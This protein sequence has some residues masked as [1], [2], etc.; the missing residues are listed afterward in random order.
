MR[1][2]M[3]NDIQETVIKFISNSLTENNSKFARIDFFGGEPLL[4]F[5]AICDIS[6][7]IKTISERLN[8]Y[9]YGGITTNA[10]GLNR[11]KLIRLFMSGIN[12]FQ[13]TLEGE[14][15][16]HDKTRILRNGEGTW[17]SITKTLLDLKDMPHD[18][19]V[20]LRVHY[21]ES[22]IASSIELIE[23]FIN[24]NFVTD[25][26]F[27][28][29]FQLIRPLGGK[30]DHMIP[31]LPES[32]INTLEELLVTHLA[33]KKMLVG[34]KNHPQVC[35]AAKPNSIVVLPSGELAKC[36]VS[37]KPVGH[38]DSNGEPVMETEQ[39]NLWTSGYRTGDQNWL[40]CPNHEINTLY[41]LPILQ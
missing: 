6:K 34:G 4:A 15:K 32:E 40:R 37:F 38:I 5:D 17:N 7:K 27:K 39:F 21:R 22:E 16:L 11:K 28:V 8:K 31:C 12:Q 25:Q 2:I 20:T 26:R 18:F 33:C 9:Y 23:Q 30:N 19:K 36:T 24:P 1:G 41:S 29:S 10:Y 35:Y 14:K 13:I 3:S